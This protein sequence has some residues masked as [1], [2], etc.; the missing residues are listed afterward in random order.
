MTTDSIIIR[1]ARVHNLQGIDLE[2]PLGRL[3]V[4][5]GVSGSGKSS[6]VHDI[7]YREGQ[8]RYLESMSSR[9]R[10]VM[11]Q[12]DHADVD[13]ISGLA[14]AISLD[15]RTVISSPRS[16][17][18]TASELHPHLR[19]LMA[20]LGQPGGPDGALE[21]SLFSF[22]TARGACPACNG[23]GLQDRV[24]PALL[25]DD[26]RKTIRQ[27]ALVLTTPRGYLM[28]SQV[29]MDALDVVCRAH[30]FSVDLP[31][32][33]L[34]EAQQRVVLHGSDRV[35][36]P[37]GKH[38]LESRLRWTGITARPRQEG[39][40]RGIIP[41]IE[42]ILS[43]KRNKGVLR[44][45]RS[46]PCSACHGSRLRSEA[47]A[48][49]LAGRNIAELAELSVDQL[50]RWARELRLEPGLRPVWEPLRDEILRRG[51][52]LRRLGVGYL[53]L[54]RPSAS[55]AGGEAQRLRLSTQVRSGLRGLLYVLD[56]PSI[57]L[58]HRDLQRLLDVLRELR[59]GGNSVLVVEHDETTILGADWLVDIGPDGG[60]G[61]GQVLYSGPLQGRPRD[62]P[63]G[64][65]ATSRTLAFLDGRQAI[66]LPTT[67][68]P[69][70][71]ELWIRGAAAR[72][73]RQV[74]AQFRLA[75]L[76]VVSGVSGSG[77]STLVREVLARALDQA[78]HASV[79]P[80]ALE[81]AAPLSKLIEIDQSPIGRTPRSNPATYTK[82]HNYIRGLLAA[83]P[84]A[85]ARGWGKGRFSFNVKG[86]RC[87]TC[88]GAGVE[89]VGMHY[90]PDVELR[91]AGCGGRRFNQE[92][93][94]VQHRDH[95]VADILELP[96]RQA[97]DLLGHH[98]GARRLLQ[99]MVDVGLGYLPLGQPATTLS[100]GEAQRVK[101]SAELGRKATG[102]T[103]YILDEPTTGL[104][105]ADV[106]QLLATLQLL[107]DQGNTVIVIEHH[108]DVIKVADWVV[109]LGPEA[110]ADGGRVL[111]MGT[112]EQVAATSGSHTG[113]A[114]APL[115]DG[116]G[117][118]AEAPPAAPAPPLAPI[119][120]RDATTHNLRG[121][122]VELPAAR[123]TAITGVSGS[124]K[125][126]LALD[127][128]VAEGAHRYAANLSTYARR[129]MQR[130]ARAQV[131]SITGL[132]PVVAIGQ[133]GSHAPRSTLGT[134]S[135]VHDDLR[136]LYSRAGV[137]DAPA[138]R[139]MSARLFSFN[140]HLGACP[141]CRGLGQVPRCD[142]ELLVRHP[143]RSL[144]DGA[145]AGHQPGDFYGDPRGQHVAI[146]SAVGAQLEL[147]LSVPWTQLPAP[148][149]RVA[150]WGTGEQTYDVTWQYRRASRQ[151]DHRW[152]TAWAGF[153]VLV[154]Q[155]YE[156]KHADR[157]AQALL[158]VMRDEVCAACRGQ[159]LRPEVLAVRFAGVGPG[160]LCSGMT[161]GQAL[162]MFEGLREP[163]VDARALQ[164]TAEV[165]RRV[166]ARLRA[167]DEVGLAYLRLDRAAAT[168]SRGE[169]RR[170]RLAGALSVGLRGVTYVLDEPTMGLHERHTR[171]LIRTLRRLRDGG[172]TVIVVEHDA[173]VIRAADQVVELGPGA[174]AAGG[175]V[176]YAGD[177]AGLARSETPTG[178]YLRQGEAAPVVPG[179]RPCGPGVQL[180]GAAR[181]NL[182]ELDLQLPGGVLAV[183]TGVSGAG[184]SSLVFGCL[185]ASAGGRAAVG[186]RA[187]R[188]LSRFGR[189]V[190]VDQRPVGGGGQS[191]PASY[192]GAL[193]G[194][195]KL[196]AATD[197]ARSRG[198][199]AARFS[200]ASKG[201]RCEA[202]RGAGHVKTGMGFLADVRVTCEQCGG[203][204]FD[205]ETLRCRHAGLSIADILRLTVSE[206]LAQFSDH[207]AICRALQPLAQ[208]GLGHLRLGQPTAT[209][210]GGENQRLKLSRRLRPERQGRASLLLLD[211][212]TCGL[213]A[214]DVA[215]LL[216]VLQAMVDAGDT[217]LVIEHHPWVMAQADW[218]IDLGP[219][220][221]EQ[222]GALV[223]EGTPEQVARHPTSHT[224]AVLRRAL[225]V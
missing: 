91:C 27:G 172:S 52:L 1:G 143:E 183:V 218:I 17:V 146:L 215:R 96:A 33:Q 54:S 186:C 20:R 165:R 24:D 16:T 73:L 64:L 223:A 203:Q 114:L 113:A 212:P 158:G 148:A 174:G 121:V 15:Q 50:A 99:A 9:T 18:G 194:I 98:A 134:L 81:G 44:F 154:Q 92:T 77:K 22:N 32:G 56:E 135:G 208:V 85:R 66:A 139:P 2:L 157:R 97:L 164:V 133:Q 84:A 13:H 144:L 53:Q 71:G 94:Q 76:N 161:I 175:R 192:S 19:L 122:D 46:A 188:G 214:Q 132:T 42:G 211:E 90:L 176:I 149:R 25:V 26:P 124:G 142:P 55:L 184:K 110:G 60:A 83:E 138:A 126:S 130:A 57:G 75:A 95:S 151:G 72:N 100:G 7:V 38:T 222:G 119:K 160:E 34:T 10:Q 199:T 169:Q 156:R 207:G 58:H 147:D 102:S 30:G 171:R 5:C 120:V 221:G 190:A 220:G 206:A 127:T 78:L 131:G 170:A 225:G 74:D 21:S 224:A 82:L 163:A 111:V 11:G 153:A 201:G 104:H 123:L 178:Q 197:Q 31:W 67:R 4:V 40:Y 37:L 150:M 128:I 79:S 93:L 36:V 209:L 198:Y 29:T 117:R 105:L 118:P 59:D 219:E 62:Q 23:L 191:N 14:P 63:A 109:D 88:Q 125:S 89:S 129:F 166:V 137:P 216:D 115:L 145:L 181:N 65:I 187:V 12:L 47:L 116:G 210:S 107:V 162:A 185:H 69:G 195:R 112:P 213:H 204:R 41:T 141:A 70:T 180:E 68:R 6:L 45:A 202:C 39:Y 35:T 43:H 200:L 80:P 140:H 87:E 101:L 205:A 3:V 48:V 136:L 179:R 177:P 196:L 189:V 182:R 61:G 8:R 193:G 86:G 159:R 155:E 167:L 173:Q 152:T 103:L 168:M 51:D 28:Y 49:S 106:Q 108:L 217:L